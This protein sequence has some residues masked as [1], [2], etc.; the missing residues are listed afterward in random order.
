MDG[1]KL[2]RQEME[3]EIQSD[4]EMD[5]SNR[6]MREWSWKWKIENQ[7][8]KWNIMR[9]FIIQM[10]IR[11]RLVGPGTRWI[12]P[13]KELFEK[14]L[15]RPKKWKDKPWFMIGPI[16]LCTTIMVYFKCIWFYYLCKL[17]RKMFW[18]L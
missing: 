1:M 12:E 9:T 6:H 7:S 18:G 13:K 5:W 8:R 15:Y 2:V 17:I 16:R 10:S 11:S 4:R 14:G 3:W